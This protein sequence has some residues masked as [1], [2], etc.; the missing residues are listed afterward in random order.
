M[1]RPRYVTI[2]TIETTV[3][4]MFIVAAATVFGWV[5]TANR[6]PEM[7][8]AFMFGLTTSKLLLLLLVNVLLLIVGCFM[9]TVAAI[10]ILVP[11]LLPMMQR[12]GV[13]PIHFGI[14]MVL[15]LMIGLLTPPVGIVL[16]ILSRVA[17]ISF[18]QT[19]VACAPWLI[20]LAV[21]LVLVTLFPQLSL[22]LPSLAYK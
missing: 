19:V 21:A 2:E 8:T 16:Y 5:L 13:D 1:Q 6:V 15:N 9:E 11:V 20:P 22:F 10:T 7:L 4:V 18:E 17:G 3:S 12:V 14:I